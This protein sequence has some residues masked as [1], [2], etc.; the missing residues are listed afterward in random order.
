MWKTGSKG[1][2]VYPQFNQKWGERGAQVEVEGRKTF[3]QDLE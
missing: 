3:Y 1:R 2:S